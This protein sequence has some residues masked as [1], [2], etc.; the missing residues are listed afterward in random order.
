ML[1][2]YALALLRVLLKI[3][4]ASE[5]FVIDYK[6]SSVHFAKNC[7]L[8]VVLYQS[9]GLGKITIEYLV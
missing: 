1:D 4:F 2:T 9:I 6:A 7:E 8:K 5:K 3:I